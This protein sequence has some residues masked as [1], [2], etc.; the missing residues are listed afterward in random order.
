MP[1]GKERSR[2]KIIKWSRYD[3]E[4]EGGPEERGGARGGGGKR[5]LFSPSCLS[6]QTFIDTLEIPEG[7]C[8]WQAIG[9]NIFF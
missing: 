4:D 3:S 6:F 5:C 9:L 1:R 7:K 8:K 2:Q